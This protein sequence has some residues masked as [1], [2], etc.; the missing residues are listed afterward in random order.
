MLLGICTVNFY[1]ADIVDHDRRIGS[2][3]QKTL[4]SQSY[5]LELQR[6][7]CK[8]YDAT[9][10]LARFENSKLKLKFENFLVMINFFVYII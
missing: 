2:C 4:W 9:N 5:N 3:S 8:N 6:Q 7:R 1:N 10:S